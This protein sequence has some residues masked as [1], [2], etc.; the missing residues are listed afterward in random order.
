MSGSDEPA[1]LVVVG[2]TASG[3]TELAIELAERCNGEI[4]SA[5]SVQ[6]YRHFELGTGKPNAEERARARHH[7]VDI[8]E[9]EQ[10][11]DAA[12][13]A[14]LAEQALTEIR[15]RAKTPIVCGGTFLWVRVLI[16]GLAAAP[17]ANAEIRA[18]HAA[19][20]RER[21]RAEL[22]GA[23][24]RVD[25]ETAQRLS[26]NDFVRVSRALEVQ[27]LTGVPMSRWQSEH[28]FRTPRHRA[29]LL[30]VERS[31]PE[32]DQRIR[33]R[34]LGMLEAGWVDEVRALRERGFAR[35]RAMGSVG[36]RQINEAL[37]SGAPPDDATLTDAIVRATRVF[38][39]RQRTWLRDQPVEWL[40]PGALPAFSER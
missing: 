2:P 32:L 19:L 16:Y 5:D 29:R 26:P 38:A 40:A 7:L 34:A 22:H 36:Y 25:P 33:S 31:K 28:G 18:R 3:K 12:H 37:A 30:G 21:G 17:P 11:C 27:E 24:A 15:S 4:V 8:M 20:A 39:R 14:T 35:A 9:P 1:L 10:H 6:V 13:W 23:L